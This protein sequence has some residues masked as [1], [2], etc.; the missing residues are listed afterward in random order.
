MEVDFGKVNEN[1]RRDNLDVKLVRII[2][3]DLTE[4][5]EK[6]ILKYQ[7]GEKV[8]EG[9]VLSNYP[10]DLDPLYKNKAKGVLYLGA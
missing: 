10:Q 3:E 5:E 8:K 9:R 4:L 2:Y 7:G 6:E 1:I